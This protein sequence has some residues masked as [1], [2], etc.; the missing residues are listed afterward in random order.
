M[1]ERT[2]GPAMRLLTG[3]AGA[4]V[5]ALGLVLAAAELRAAYLGSPLAPTVL[6]AAGCLF[7]AV[8]GASL[9]RSALRGRIA[10]RRIRR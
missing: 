4:A 7:A 2:L 9:V 6:V 5:F 3:V 1:S 10:L 8:G